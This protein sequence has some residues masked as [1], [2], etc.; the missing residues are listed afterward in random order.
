[1]QLAGEQINTK[2]AVLAGS[3]R[4]RYANDLARATLQHQEVT[5]A[6]VVTR[7]GYSVRQVLAGFRAAACNRSRTFTDLDVNM[8]LM[9]VATW[10]DN[11]IRK[12]VHALAK[13][14]VMA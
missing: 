9:M 8:L 6:D 12:L 7:D 2:I 4:G 3:R 1:M 14:V 13:R 11:T 10:V 5:D